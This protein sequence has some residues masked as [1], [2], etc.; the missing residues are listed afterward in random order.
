MVAL[1]IP[2][3]WDTAVCS[4]AGPSHQPPCPL[5]PQDLVSKMLHVDPHQRLTA[6]QVLQHPWITQKDK[7]PQSQLS[8]Q[9]LQLVK[10]WSSQLLGIQGPRQVFLGKDLGW[11]GQE[12]PRLS[13][14]EPRSNMQRCQQYTPRPPGL[15]G[16]QPLTSDVGGRTT[17]QGWING[18]GRAVEHWEEQAWPWST[19]P[20]SR[21]Y[22]SIIVN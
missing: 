6:K 4:P 22:L 2:Q 9:D 8:H 17:A 5:C 20:S 10:V 12:M 1:P 3:Q 7:L 16:S 13:V 21:L 18:A 15:R 11:Q 19:C 14:L